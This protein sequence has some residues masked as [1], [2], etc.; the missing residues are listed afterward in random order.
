MKLFISLGVPY[1][2]A[3]VDRK[4]NVVESGS[5]EDLDAL[6]QPKGVDEIIG[7]APAESVVIRTATVPSKRRSNVESAIP[8]ALEESLSEEVESLQ[9]ALLD[10]TPGQAATVAVIG[11]E[12]LAAWVEGF[13]AKGMALDAIVPEF[14][15][16]PLHGE[17]GITV[18]RTEADRIC[19]RQGKFYGLLLDDYAFEIWWQQLEE[20]HGPIAVNDSE[21]AKRLIAAGGE[22]VRQWE[23]GEDFVSWLREDAAPDLQA[24]SLLTGE[25]APLHRQQGKAGLKVAAIL[26]GVAYAILLTANYIEYRQ[27]RSEYRVLKK[28]IVG[29]FVRTFPGEK[30]VGRPRTQVEGLL[31]ALKG[32]GGSD[33]EQFLDALKEVLPRHRAQLEEIT[34]RDHAMLISCTAG[35]FAALDQIKQALDQ[36]PEINAALV[37]SG[38]RD[39]Q[40]NGRFRLTRGG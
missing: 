1:R 38:S 40:V 17:Q 13:S 34:Y 23:I 37:S 15:L 7:V 4:G 2:W 9:F 39:N 12:L 35:N 27:L 20:K 31:A 3:V 21:L 29:L 6:G 14:L 10:W 26:F 19:V 22:E 8:Y 16:L 18:A 28:E 32:S 5:V 36:Q 11:K 33:F 25:F 24:Y 30:Y